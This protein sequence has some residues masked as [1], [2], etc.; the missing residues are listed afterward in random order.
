[1]GERRTIV[2][3]G[4]GI[5][6]LTAALALAGKGF[7]VV[8]VERSPQLSEIGAGIQLA[9][10]AGRILADLGLDNAIAAAAI[11]P[12]AIDVM[13]GR[14]GR[15]LTSVPGERFRARYGFPYR[16]IHRADLQTILVA[17]ANRIRIRI[18]LGATVDGFITQP[19]ALLVRIRKAA[20]GEVVSAAAVIAAD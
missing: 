2:I 10:N 9:P 11:E 14:S 5:G 1:M 15:R 16:V 4:A 7:L 3:A 13:D 18:E 19:G 17:A 8:V 20:G 6:G 12:A